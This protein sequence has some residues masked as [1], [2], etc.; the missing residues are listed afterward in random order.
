MCGITA[1]GITGFSHVGLYI[2]N[3]TRDE[4]FWTQVCNA[5]VSDRI[6]DA[7]LMRLGTIHHSLA[8]FP[9]HTRDR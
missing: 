8:L 9:Y 4:A 7:P 2:T 3:A 5:R 6:G 1:P